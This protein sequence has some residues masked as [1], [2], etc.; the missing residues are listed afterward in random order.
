[1]NPARVRSGEEQQWLAT[2]AAVTAIELAWWFGAWL[3]G[4]AP[5]PHL[6]I[7]LA[8]AFVGLAAA[9]LVRLACG[10][11]ATAPHWRSVLV[12]TLLVGIGASAFLPLKYAIPN[13]IGFWLDKPVALAERHLFGTDPWI[14]LNRLLGWATVPMDRLYGCWMPV[15]TLALFSL[16]LAG[17]SPAKSRALIAYSLAWFLLG[18]VAAV[19]LSSAGP[20]FYDRLYGGHEFRALD[21]MLRARGGSIALRESDLMWA[22]R[23]DSSPGVIAGISALPSIHVAISLWMYLAARGNARKLALPAFLYFMLIWVGSVQLGWH[24]AVDGLAGAI[25]ML[26]VW[27][28]AKAV[29]AISGRKALPRHHVG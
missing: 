18:V 24:Y 12:A 4:I 3:M 1:V 22:S 2:M 8:F 5:A 6:F 11:P 15:Q 25:G 9:I 28:L 17:P 16:I 19:L 10:L 23:G 21:A 20:L 13:E 26:A 14:L 7:Y 27:L 29:Q